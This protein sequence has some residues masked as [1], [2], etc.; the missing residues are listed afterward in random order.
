MTNRLTT[1]DTLAPADLIVAVTACALPEDVLVAATAIRDATE[2][3]TPRPNAVLVFP[4][5]IAT[6]VE[7]ALEGL[8]P[9]PALQW[10]P[11]QLHPLGRMPFVPGDDQALFQPLASIADRAGAQACV[12][13]GGLADG[14]TADTIQRLASPVIAQTIDLVLPSYP[15]HALDGLINSGI[16]YPLTRALY[17]QRVGGQLGLDFGFSRRMLSALGERRSSVAQGRAIWLLAEAAARGMH[18]A[19]AHVSAWRP[20]VEAATDASTALAEVLG[21]LFDDME[22][23]A[24]TWQR[25]RGSRAVLVVGEET[26]APDEPR[27]LDITPMVES[28][29]LGFRN[30]Q[31]VWGRLLPPATLVELSRLTRLTPDQFRMPDKLWARVVCD[32]AI[33]HRLRVIRREHLLRA[34]T[35]VYLGWVASF[36]AE[37]GQA[38]RYAA[39]TRVERLCLAYEAEKPYLLARWRWPDRFN[40]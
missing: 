4:E 5:A 38:S 16:V 22:H 37:T 19:Q 34:L 9:D 18:V 14:I 26:G 11:H 25:T 1:L 39:R 7:D 3:T 23:H 31:D 28:F 35:P 17:G 10:L 12:L 2:R 40:P 36:V 20:P 33:G 27:T 15:R 8:T 6:N 32:F 29:Q 24:S 30:L 13:I 21:S